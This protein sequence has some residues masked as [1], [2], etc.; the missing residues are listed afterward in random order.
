MRLQW[1][2]S[3]IINL[4]VL[5]ILVAF[6]VLD[7]IKARNDLKES[8][9]RDVGDGAA[10]KE[11]ADKIRKQ[12]RDEIG[13]EGEFDQ[14]RIENA[15][16]QLKEL[17]AT[18][19]PVLAIHVT[20]QLDTQ[21]R[22]SLVPK[23]FSINATPQDISAHNRD[24][25]ALLRHG[26]KNSGRPLS[27]QAKI[28]SYL[29]PTVE[30]QDNVLLIKE[31]V[32]LINDNQRTYTVRWVGDKLNVYLPKTDY[33]IN[34]TR[35][36]LDKIRADGVQ[37]FNWVPFGNGYATEMTVPYE[38]TFNDFTSRPP[39]TGF[40]QIFFDAPNIA[41]HI[42]EFRLMHLILAIVVSVLLLIVIDITTTRLIMMP[43]ER[44]ME[45]IKHAEA[46]DL[47]SLPRSYSSGEIGRVT[48]SLARM[49]SQ[50]QQSHSKRIGAL[51]QLAAGVAHEIR[52][53]LNSIGMAAQYLKGLFSE[54]KRVEIQ[55]LE[56]AKEFLDIIDDEIEKLKRISEQ[57]LTLNRPK[58]LNRK[59]TDLNELSDKVLSEFTLVLENAKVNVITKYE[60]NLP[61]LFVD[62]DLIRQVFFNLV[63]NSI[64]A[65]PKG[66]SI[67]I[68]TTE[69]EEDGGITTKSE[70]D[71]NGRTA[72]I[73]IRDTGL[74]IPEGIQEQIFDAY[75]TTRGEQGGMGLGLAICHQVITAHGGEIVLQSKI[76]MGTM[77]EIHLPIDEQDSIR[78]KG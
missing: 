16:L 72:L 53:P 27:A 59:R 20:Q 12:V 15:L 50:L 35:D 77:F 54:P 4:S 70:K 52:N 31:N 10:F 74:G 45:I 62:A 25:S 24:L 73:Q 22:A 36:K 44:M 13:G 64:Q 58:A 3:L 40:I 67:Y 37:V 11:I 19:A 1:K 23:L 39:I 51:G 26:F 65:M 21:I 75:F 68:T 18:M 2:Y 6:F 38:I 56:E 46:D 66:G 61:P 8:H 69:L 57:F 30:R 43:L 34:F 33:H 48:S 49:L 60:V 63:Q 55:D 32:L 5:V 41:R 17:D 29:N 14:R 78:I 42:N 71:G 76:G 7:D 28:I 47:E 9:I